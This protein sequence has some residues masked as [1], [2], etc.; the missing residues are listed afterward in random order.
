MEN[1]AVPG[2]IPANALLTIEV[3]VLSERSDLYRWNR[4]VVAER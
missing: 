4:K 2:V 3:T 1:E